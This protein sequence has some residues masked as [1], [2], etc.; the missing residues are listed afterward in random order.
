MLFSIYWNIGNTIVNSVNTIIVSEN[1]LLAYIL[2]S[3]R[4]WHNKLKTNTIYVVIIRVP[5][6]IWV[7]R[8][9][10]HF[11]RSPIMGHGQLRPSRLEWTHR[12]QGGPT[13]WPNILCNT[14]THVAFT[15][16]SLCPLFRPNNSLR[17]LEGV[18]KHDINRHDNLISQNQWFIFHETVRQIFLIWLAGL[19]NYVPNY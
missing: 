17:K 19:D 12:F 11:H 16:L 13:Y 3:Y 8:V 2:K 7:I 6:R 18:V 9:F 15:L 4:S 10:S 14:L 1:K 5:D